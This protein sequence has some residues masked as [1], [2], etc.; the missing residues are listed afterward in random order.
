MLNTKF[1]L[2]HV[3]NQMTE[4]LNVVESSSYPIK[5]V[6]AVPYIIIIVLCHVINIRMKLIT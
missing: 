1:F 5:F 2:I 6:L 3:I 4:N